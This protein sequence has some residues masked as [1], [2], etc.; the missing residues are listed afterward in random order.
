[1]DSNQLLR[2]HNTHA[3][4]RCERCLQKRFGDILRRIQPPARRQYR[5]EYAQRTHHEALARTML[6][7]ITA[8]RAGAHESQR[9]KTDL[10]Q[11]VLQLAL[12]SKV[13]NT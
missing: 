7:A 10:A 4:L 11:I 1:M 13:E 2:S 5:P 3:R 12:H 8:N 6:L 9:I